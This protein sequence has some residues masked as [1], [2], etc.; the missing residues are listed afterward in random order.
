MSFSLH[1]VFTYSITDIGQRSSRFQGD[2]AK[3]IEVRGI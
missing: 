1:T 3:R 2:E